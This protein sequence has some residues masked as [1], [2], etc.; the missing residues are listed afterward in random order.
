MALINSPDIMI[1]N[2]GYN[3]QL[4]EYLKLASRSAD[5]KAI[6]Q[7]VLEKMKRLQSQTE[8]QKKILLQQFITALEDGNEE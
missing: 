4:S 7:Q 5:S 3:S 6:V 2:V 1:D 8:G